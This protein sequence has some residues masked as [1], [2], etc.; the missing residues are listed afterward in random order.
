MV[1]KPG[2]RAV[3]TGQMIHYMSP[4]GLSAPWVGNELR[5]VMRAGVP[6]RLYAMRSPHQDLHGFDWAQRIHSETRDLYPINPLRLILSSTQAALRFPRRL[7]AAAC[8][9]L[10]GKREHVRARLAGVFHLLV[11][12]DWIRRLSTDEVRHIHSQWIHSCGTIAMYGA[13]LL[14]VP[15]S[16]TGHAADLFRDRCALADKIRRAKFIVCI[17]EFHRQFYLDHGARPEQLVMVYCGIDVSHFAFCPVSH[18]RQGP[19]HILSSGRLVEKKGFSVLIDAC[20][21]LRD[22][23]Q[24]FRCTIAGSGPLESALRDQIARHGLEDLVDVTGEP[25]T[26]EAIPAFMRTGHIY[27]LPCVW[28]KDGDVDGLPQML[29]EA[30]ACG[31]PAVSTRLVGIPDLIIHNETGLLV[32]PHQTEELAD[33]LMRLAH[34]PGLADRLARAGRRHIEQTF[35]IRTCLQPLIHQFRLSLG[36]PESGIEPPEPATSSTCSEAG[37]PKLV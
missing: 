4:I 13:W 15:F 17:S 28:A 19:V 7:I 12:C 8:N 16:F 27:C 24:Q 6:V 21:V 33:A 10:F 22:R 5:W 26:Q 35:D 20:A 23:G 25:L 34:D 32:E 3:S 18:D 14:E 2:T 37:M 30:M 36:Q 1:F 9:A 11:A 29:M 31:L